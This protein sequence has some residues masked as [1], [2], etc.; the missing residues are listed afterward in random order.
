MLL[1]SIFRNFRWWGVTK[2]IAFVGIFFLVFYIT[3]FGFL[4]YTDRYVDDLDGNLPYQY[5]VWGW[6]SPEYIRLADHLIGDNFF[7]LDGQYPEILRTPAYPIL[8]ALTKIL[9][10]S[11]KVVILFQIILTLWSGFLIYKIGKKLY[12][13]RVG[14]IAGGIFLLNPSTIFNSL[15]YLTDAPF[16][17]L[18]VLIAYMLFFKDTSNVEVSGLANGALIAGLT[19]AVATLT[20][21]IALYLPVLVVAGYLV[22]FRARGLRSNIKVL[23]FFVIGFAVIVFPWMLRNKIETGNFTVSSISLYNLTYFNTPDF[24]AKKFGA[25][26][27]ELSSYNEKLHASPLHEARPM[28]SLTELQK[29]PLSFLGLYPVP[30]ALYHV[31]S[32]PTFF[33][34]SS[35]RYIVQVTDNSTVKEL[36]SL[37]ENAPNILSLLKGGKFLELFETLRHQLL[38]TVDR[39]ALLVITILAFI[40]PLF[41]P[42]GVR[43]QGL[44]L[45]ALILYFA[46]LTGP[47]SIPR[48]RLPADPFILLL[49]SVSFLSLWDFLKKKKV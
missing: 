8:L 29:L 47:A 25:D 4:L 27:I 38:F 49:A 41:L 26:S 14:A 13:S 18:I 12:D 36:F 23:I 9:F 7:S 44:F 2:K 24:L 32:L 11:Y 42:K 16:T 48:Y 10:G 17:F 33:L 1:N 3:L 30:Y 39:V 19:L 34:S 31:S 5:P 28:V 40:A 46:I 15:V 35:V 20:R 22:L 45:I 6:D 37:K 43:M 21:P